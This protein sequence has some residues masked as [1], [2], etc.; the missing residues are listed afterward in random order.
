V[1]TAHDKPLTFIHPGFDMT[2]NRDEHHDRKQ[3]RELQHPYRAWDLM[4]APF[5]HIRRRQRLLSPRRARS[6]SWDG[7]DSSPAP[8]IVDQSVDQRLVGIF[9]QFDAT[10]QYFHNFTE[11]GTS[12]Q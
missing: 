11:Y 8:Q 5:R 1:T 2:A 7:P 12:G 9:W 3:R 10:S 4:I 6:L